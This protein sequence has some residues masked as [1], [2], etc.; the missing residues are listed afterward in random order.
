MTIPDHELL[1]R[2]GSGAF[3]EV[4]L[5]RSLTG[6]Y[7]AVKVIRRTTFQNE[8]SFEREFRGVQKAEPISREHEGL[9]DILHVGRSGDGFYYIMELADD[10]GGNRQ[11]DPAKYT[12]KTL[13]CTLGARWPTAIVVQIARSLTA[14][15]SGQR[16]IRKSVS[17]TLPARKLP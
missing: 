14:R 7:R 12:P 9:V 2:I 1:R 3:G 5:A 17:A 11:V 16:P 15:A 10:V 8:N 6:S 13:H 4:W